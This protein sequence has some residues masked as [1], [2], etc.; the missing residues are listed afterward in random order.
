ME[1]LPLKLHYN[2]PV[3][4]DSLSQMGWRVWLGRARLWLGL[5]SRRNV[6]I[7]KMG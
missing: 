5:S 1:P 7:S 3:G 2:A 6:E 4:L